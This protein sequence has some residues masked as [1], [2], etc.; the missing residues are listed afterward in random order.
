MCPICVLKALY[1]P[2]NIQSLQAKF[3]LH[4]I[5]IDKIRH[6][7]RLDIFEYILVDV[8]IDGCGF[9]EFL[10]VRDLRARHLERKSDE[11]R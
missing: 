7:H 10:F 8:E 4:V 2:Y 11:R 5:F 6:Q 9:C 1:L 3:K